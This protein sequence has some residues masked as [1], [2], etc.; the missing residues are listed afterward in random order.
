MFNK[1]KQQITNLNSKKKTEGKPE[2][3]EDSDNKVPYFFL[4]AHDLNSSRILSSILKI[5]G[6]TTSRNFASI[7]ANTKSSPKG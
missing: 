4:F 3:Q 2:I 6:N 1:L 5:F 7:C